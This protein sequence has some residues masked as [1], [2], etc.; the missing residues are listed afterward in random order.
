MDDFEKLGVF[1]LGRVYDLE[2]KQLK[3]D[4]LLYDSKDLT[5]H[6]VCI[7]MTGSGKTGLCISLIEEA[8]IDGVP[9]ILIDPKGDLSNLCLSFPDLNPSDF[10]PWINLDSA[11]QKGLSPDDYAVKQADTWKKG[12]ADWGQTGERIK[13]LKEASEVLIYT[14]GS[15]AGLPVSILSSFSAPSQSILEDADLLRDRINSTITSLLGLIGIK[16]DP[17]K[18]REHIFLSTIMELAWE[19]GQSVDLASLIQQVQDPPVTRIGILDLESFFPSKDRFD[20][21]MALNNLLAS[22]GF[23]TWL[24]G[25]PLE[26]D[27]ILYTPTGKPRIAI[28][29]ISHLS[30]SERMFFV[31]LLMNQILSWTRAQPGTNSLRALVYMDEIFGFLPPVENP[32][33]KLP[34]LSLLKQARA[35]GV[36]MMFATQN[37]VDLDYK[38]LS[39][40]G[41]WFIGRLQT[42][43]DKS[44]LLDGLESAS[45][46]QNNPFSRKSIEKTISRLDNRVFLM[47]N[48][49]E[50]SPEIFHTRWALS[51]LRGPMTRDDIKVLMNPIRQTSGVDFKV[52]S[53]AS[54][55]F[56]QI[57]QLSTQQPSL[58]PNISSFF[59]PP[60]GNTS[61]D[62]KLIYR[63]NL[64]G[65]A[66]VI[67]LNTQTNQTINRTATYIT[68]LSDGAIPVNWESAEALHI[69]AADLEKYPQ[70]NALFSDLPSAAIQTSSYTSWNRAFSTWI[71]GSQTLEL[72]Y[73]PQ[74]KASSVPDET[75][76]DFRIRLQQ[77]TREKRDE[78]TEIIR[79]KYASKEA[80][81]KEKLRKAEQAVDKQQDQAKRAKTQTAIS[82]AS[83]LFGA[84]SGRKVSQSTISRASTAMR[85]ASRT[86]EESKDVARA[87]DTVESIK[88]R[89]TELHA[90]FENE[91][92]KLDLK[93]NSLSENLEKLTVKPR[94]TDILVQL[95]SLVWAPYWQ[96]SQGSL[97]PAW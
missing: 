8:A 29:S 36:G 75:E 57:G 69:P 48:T 93:F 50:S 24:Q 77:L 17:L 92:S 80:Q 45:A 42:E 84:I 91:V 22:P 71:Y 74:L 21:V 9:A 52:T 18:S 66:K 78:T 25:T 26:I 44:R 15:N 82:F 59:I 4:L 38:A 41:T 12:L 3:D 83:T 40:T 96:D 2:N 33:S 72:L 51:Y 14:P 49:H 73:S 39:N 90:E 79:S 11:R 94:K 31:S 53:V 30:D 88:Q 85:S 28:F 62:K 1:Y 5:T 7:G 64:L 23:S 58:P 47:N 35:F 97:S 32:P 65:V 55:T 60:R 34:M 10:R 89:I 16:A 70:K 86:L 67:F 68:P 6:A 76:K 63:P 27:Q 37:P 56:E 81:L 20:L 54:K 43:Q 46:G 19:K 95:V 87:G 13:R 61:V